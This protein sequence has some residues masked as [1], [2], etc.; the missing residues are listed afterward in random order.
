MA[1]ANT[2][3]E[4]IAIETVCNNSMSTTIDTQKTR[5]GE[6]VLKTTSSREHQIEKKLDYDTTY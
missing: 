3:A 6:L 2:P 1:A 5:L 4:A